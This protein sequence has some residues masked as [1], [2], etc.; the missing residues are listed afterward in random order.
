[1]FKIRKT[2]MTPNHS[3]FIMDSANII[4]ERQ[5]SKDKV[6]FLSDL[7]HILDSRFGGDWSVLS[8]RAVGYVMKTRKKASIILSES[9]QELLVCWRS[10]GFEVEDLDVVKIKTSLVLSEVDKLLNS[11]SGSKLKV[12]RSP[13][14][15][16]PVYTSDTP[17]V[18]KVLEAVA[19][20]VKDMEHDAAARHI[21]SQYVFNMCLFYSFIV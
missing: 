13:T 1:M 18:L 16:S 7:K 9:G 15:D 12:I 8:G 2:D 11:Q 6:I 21:R 3:T 20:E 17:V 4:K 14:V 10:P 19:D 5:N